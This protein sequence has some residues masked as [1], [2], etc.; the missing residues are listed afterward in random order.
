MPAALASKDEVIDRLFPVFRDRGFEGASLADLSRASGLG[1]SSL[2][3]YFPGGKEEMAEAVLVRALEV[4]EAVFAEPDA[5]QKTLKQRIRHVVAAI[6]GIYA[7]GR[8]ACLL[9]QFA[10]SPLAAEGRRRLHEAFTR[11]IDA[12]EALAVEA[13]LTPVRARDFAE[14]WVARVQGALLLQ[15]ATGGTGPFDRAMGALLRL[16]NKDGIGRV[17]VQETA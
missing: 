8:N 11:W 2:Y 17:S 16:A 6:E 14:D 10:T 12:V 9:G 5:S 15:A 13:G 3:H 7:G 4:T 1:R